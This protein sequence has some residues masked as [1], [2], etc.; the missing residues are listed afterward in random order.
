MN[1]VLDVVVSGGLGYLNGLAIQRLVTVEAAEKSLPL[2]EIHALAPPPELPRLSGWRKLLANVSLWGSW[3][4]GLSEIALS[5]A[6]AGALLGAAAYTPPAHVEAAGPVIAID[7]LDFQYPLVNGDISPHD[8][9]AQLQNGVAASLFT[10]EQNFHLFAA[11]DNIPLM[12][13]S[14]QAELRSIKP[15]GGS[16]NIQSAVKIELA[17][18]FTNAPEAQTNV[19]SQ[20]HARSGALLILDN[21]ESIGQADVIIQQ[22][23]KDGDIP[24]YIANAES[25]KNKAN[26]QALKEISTATHGYYWQLTQ[27][28]GETARVAKSIESTIRP[29]KLV[30]ETNN[31]ETR[32][33]DLALAGLIIVAITAARKGQLK[34]ANKT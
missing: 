12:P 3:R 30:G 15:Y 8:E 17:N 18:G 2:T 10:H 9:T 16:N 20:V 22:A 32:Y 34:L 27:A 21:N 7:N 23:K 6:T 13:V 4:R 11:T 14:N 26:T 33:I 28:K 25:N 31:N 24:V 19:L 29:K 5:G 1:E